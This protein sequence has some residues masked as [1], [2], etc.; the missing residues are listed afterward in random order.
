MAE[1]GFSSRYAAK[2]LGKKWYNRTYFVIKGAEVEVFLAEN[3]YAKNCVLIK[4]F[5]A[6]L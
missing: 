3:R 4:E 2:T 6:V 1:D 5:W